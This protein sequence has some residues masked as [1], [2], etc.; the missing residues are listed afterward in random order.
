VC[1]EETVRA[2]RIEAI[3]NNSIIISTGRSLYS[4]LPDF[5]AKDFVY[6][7]AVGLRAIH[8]CA[9][10]GRRFFIFDLYAF[11]PPACVEA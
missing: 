2:T 8:V 7:V 1:P 5:A 9:H 4:L 10:L 3:G 11:F 6:L